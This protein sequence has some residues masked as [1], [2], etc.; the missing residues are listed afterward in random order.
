MNRFTNQI[1]SVGF[2]LFSILF[3]GG[4]ALTVVYYVSP[5]TMAKITAFYDD[6]ISVWDEA[7]CEASQERCLEAKLRE[8]ETLRTDLDKGIEQ[9][10]EQIVTQGEIIT[11]H[12]LLQKANTQ[13][14]TQGRKQISSIATTSPEQPIDV[15]FSGQHFSNVNVLKSQLSLL[16]REKGVLASQVKQADSIKSQ[17]VSMREKLIINRGDLNLEIKMI[18]SKLTLLRSS[19]FLQDFDQSVIRIDELLNNGYREL[20]QISDVILNTE[21]FVRQH[22]NQK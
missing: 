16:E 2:Y 11:H 20:K 3:W 21:E 4:I 13:L 9:L 12:E 8:L 18:P 1:K 15:W 10:N 7:A 19:Q 14:I 6:N 17:L 5:A 22:A